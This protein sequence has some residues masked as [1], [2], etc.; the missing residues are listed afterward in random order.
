VT[1]QLATRL[2][3]A[4]RWGF[5]G[6]L[7]VGYAVLSHFTATSTTH[8]L[9]GALVAVTPMLVLS[10]LLAWRSVRRAR[11]L[12]LWLVV[13]ALL[14]GSKNW[15]ITHYNWVF[16]LE[17]AGTYLMLCATFGLSLRHGET[18]M[19]SRFAHIV[20]G[21]MSTALIRYTRSATWAWTLYFGGIAGMSLL[22]FWL[23]PV[24][25]WSAFAYLLGIP[26]LVLMFMGEYAARCYLLPAAERA[27]PLESIRAYRKASTEGSAQPGS[28]P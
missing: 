8:A 15:L 14:Y 9:L 26:L 4:C 17:H 23:A 20:H 5:I 18:P 10:F 28:H 16:L 24:N 27:G 6:L 11:M 12:T 1:S 7:A 21:G 13:C 2:L 25:V 3:Q 19:I 22:L